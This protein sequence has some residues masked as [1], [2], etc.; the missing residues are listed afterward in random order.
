MKE[1]IISYHS[2]KKFKERTRSWDILNEQ[3]YKHLSL[4]AQ[5]GSVT[6]RC[7]GDLYEI[8]YNGEAVVARIEKNFI[9]VVTYL[10]N[11]AYRQWFRQKEIKPR[12]A[13]AL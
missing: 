3:A 10:G 6:R 8:T 2:I 13:R 1:I 4:I 7:P 12:Y 11:K 5:R 9:K